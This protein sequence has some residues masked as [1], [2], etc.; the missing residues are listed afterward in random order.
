M[1]PELLA[2]AGVMALGQFSPGPD[3]ILLTRTALAQGRAAG[4]W[5]TAGITAGLCVHAALAIGGMAYLMAQG[6]WLALGLR[7]AAALYLGWLAWGLLRS[8]WRGAKDMN[9]V[10]EGVPASARASFR[11][12]FLCNLLNPK[13]A[14]FFAGVVAKF[15]VGTRP[16]WWPVALWG[17]IVGQGLILWGFYVAFLQ[18]PPFQR[19]YLSAGR[20]IDGA[21]GLGLGGLAVGLVLQGG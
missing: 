3:M 13:A 17:I 14:L 20:W 19:G 15:V 6:G 18:F 5:T 1:V 2:F 11:R 9:A 21:F 4:W 10:G 12:G 7:W 16:E 8:A